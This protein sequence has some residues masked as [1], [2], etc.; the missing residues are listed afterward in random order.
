MSGQPVGLPAEGAD[1][2]PI[3]RVF[4]IDQSEAETRTFFG[5]KMRVRAILIDRNVVGTRTFSTKGRKGRG[6][7]N[8]RLT[9]V[10]RALA[11]F[12]VEKMRV[13]TI[14]N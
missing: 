3:H 14:F 9:V 11:L 4:P 1:E 6:Q 7:G 2:S 12:F 10:K 8:L 5:E 13:R